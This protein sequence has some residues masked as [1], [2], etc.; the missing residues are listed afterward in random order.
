MDSLPIYPMAGSSLE[1]DHALISPHTLI[2]FFPRLQSSKYLIDINYP[3]EWRIGTALNPEGDYYVA[4]SYDHLVDS[5]IL[6]GRLSYADT[7]MGNAKIEIFTYSQNDKIKSK[8][9]LSEMHDM[10]RSSKEFL[11]DLPVNRY[12][13]LY[14]FETNASI[15]SNT[16]GNTAY[17]AWEHATSSEY[18]FPEVD[19][20]PQYMQ[21]VT[22]VASHEFFHIVTPLN[23]H[24]EYIEY[25]N[26][27]TPN[28]SQHIWFYEGITEWA[29]Q[30]LLYRGGVTSTEDYLKILGNKVLVD[31]MF[32]PNW[33]LKDM[34]TLSYTE[35]GQKQWGNIYSRGALFG[36]ILDI[37]LL[38]KSEGREGLRELIIRLIQKYGPGKPFKEED[39]FDEI[40]EMT[41]P[42]IKTLLN[43]H[44]IGSKPLPYKEYFS[45]IGIEFI[46]RDSSG[47]GTFKLIENMNERQEK[48]YNSWN[49]NINRP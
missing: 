19:P 30:M 2:G 8:Q 15:S 29:S 33:T 13:F 25:F 23:I 47:R 1:K 20:T 12:T 43:D 24:S 35:K 10:F 41:H 27:E 22:Q 46:D 40:V 3:A 36:N 42:E 37:A 18:V 28:P 11:I 26:Y 4:K 14:H 31:R 6:L 5:P 9:L 21:G 17:G 32:D 45:K 39:F 38:D 49:V 16:P 7:V 48:M 34:G 44:V